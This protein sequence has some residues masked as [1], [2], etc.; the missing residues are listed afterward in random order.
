MLIANTMEVRSG[1]AAAPSDGTPGSE[2]PA[3][4]KTNT[5]LDLGVPVSPLPS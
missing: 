2:E 1:H 5:K 3:V 4:V